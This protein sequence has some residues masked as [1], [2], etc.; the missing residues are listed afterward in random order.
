M[1]QIL[2]AAVAAVLG[3]AIGAVVYRV[4]LT[5]RKGNA[6]E[7][8]SAMRLDAEK[9]CRTTIKD[10]ELK[11]KEIRLQSKQEVEEEF[12][13]RKEE[14]S[15]LEKHLFQKEENISKKTDYLDGKERDMREREEQTE[16]T[17]KKLE[18][19]RERMDELIQEQIH[20]LEKAAGMSRDEA[21]QKLI[22]SMIDE[23]KHDGAKYI[24]QVEDESRETAESKSKNIIALAIQRYSGEYVTEKTVSVVGL[25][26]DDMKGR[27]IG[28]EGRN[29]RALEAAT[30]IDLI[31]DDTPEAVV[32]SGFNPIRREIARM[33]LDRLIEDGRIHPARIEEIVQKCEVDL[34]AKIKELGQQAAFDLGLHGINSELIKLVGRLRYRTSYGQNVW[35]HSIEVAFIAG[36]MASELGQSVSMARRAGLLHDIGKALTHEIEGSHAVIGADLAKKYGEKT[37]I[38]HAIRAHHEDEE[39]S[40]I[41]AVLVQ[42]ADALSGARPGA[43]REIVES[44]VKRLGDLEDIA[45]SFTG[46]EKSFAIQ[47]GREIRVMVESDKI[48]DDDSV[49]LA[50]DIAKKIESELTYPG[51]IK[52]TVIRETRA[53]SIAN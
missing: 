20:A 37:E 33:A 45:R 11:A 36:I 2:I 25:P 53:T 31:I 42:A 26:S 41:L 3:I 22:D 28:R 17:R 14:L 24:K 27:I 8:I 30:G 23:A 51:Q 48:N 50:R 9:E 35:Q 39:P 12:K 19:K 49:V 32:L 52:V 44:Y 29:I 21:R 38:E 34:D 6:E 40:T 18:K 4:I 13:K 16:K 10:A 5:A 43:R 7:I 15:K 47:A 1:E 46:V